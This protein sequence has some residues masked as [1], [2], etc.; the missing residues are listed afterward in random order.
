MTRFKE[1][2]K[3][4]DNLMKA[5]TSYMNDETREQVHMELAP[6]SNEQFLTRYVEL[7]PGFEDMLREEFGIE[8]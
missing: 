4:N 3:I 5:I 1:E 6:C 8:F 2:I 7:D